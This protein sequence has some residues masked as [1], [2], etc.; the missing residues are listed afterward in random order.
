VGVRFTV[1]HNSPFE[2]EM[3]KIV[4]ASET[5]EQECKK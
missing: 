2:G 3:T 5:T 1:P 4:C